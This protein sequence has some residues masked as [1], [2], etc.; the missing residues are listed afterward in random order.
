MIDYRVDRELSPLEL[1]QT[2]VINDLM[3]SNSGPVKA[4]KTE[5]YASNVMVLLLHTSAIRWNE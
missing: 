3:G 1:Q 2:S 4:A 5:R